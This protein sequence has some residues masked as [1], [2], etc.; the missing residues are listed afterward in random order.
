MILIYSIASVTLIS[1]FSLV[2]VFTISL[3]DKRLKSIVFVLVSLSVGAL[4]GDAFIHLIPEALEETQNP[5]IVSLSILIG[6]I[7]FFILEKFFRW[8]HV[9]NHNECD[10][11]ND[12]PKHVGSL[13]L[14]SDGAHNLIDGILIGASYMISIEVGIATTIAVILHEIP[15][16]IGDFGLLIHAG[17]SRGKALLWNLISALT[18][19]AGV[20]IGIGA[21][22]FVDSMGPI[23]AGVAAGGFIYIAGSDLVPELHKTKEVKKS[24]IQLIA[25]LAG[26]GLMLG[27]LFIAK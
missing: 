9:H 10:H 15:Q 4:F 17:F 26:I 11:E 13:I 12:P 16:E 22:N 21:T 7:F 18:A 6:I 24:I 14:I 20:F 3:S 25:I 23:L 8:H 1:L 19:F 5:I 27:L 2:G